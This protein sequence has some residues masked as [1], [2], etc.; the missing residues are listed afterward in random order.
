LK[1]IRQQSVTGRGVAWHT[2]SF[3]LYFV[4][5]QQ[6]GQAWGYWDTSAR[7][8]MAKKYR[9][10][11]FVGEPPAAAFSGYIILKTDSARKPQYCLKDN[12]IAQFA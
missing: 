6:D 5:P 7:Q 1:S 8:W 2:F 11:I 4:F 9:K 12:K 3:F 10:Y